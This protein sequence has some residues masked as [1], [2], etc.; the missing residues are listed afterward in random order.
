MVSSIWYERD[1]SEGV[2]TDNFGN[3]FIA[4]YT[5]GAVPGFETAGSYD[6]FVT[7]LC[8]P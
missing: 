5:D 3:V 6:A 1:F 7:R 2:A 4:D 8:A